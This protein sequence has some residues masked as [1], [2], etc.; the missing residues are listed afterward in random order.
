MTDPTPT[1]PPADP[2]ADL[3][4]PAPEET[5]PAA[6][7]TQTLARLRT[8]GWWGPAS[9]LPVLAWRL[10][11]GGLA[12]Q[13]LAVLTTTGRRTGAP[14]RTVVSHIPSGEQTYVV[15]LYGPGSQWFR[16][17]IADP[18]V[19]VQTTG[20]ARAMLARRLAGD[21]DLRDAYADLRRLLGPGVDAMLGVLGVPGGL[22]GLLARRDR[23]LLVRLEATEG[24]TPPPVRA[25]LAWAPPLLLGSL[26]VVWARSR[27]RRRRRRRR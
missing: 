19:T 6:R 16:N 25:D 8:L 14:R 9:R 5:P 13:A 12:G 21:D 2:Q 17:V 7:L 15:A 10:G 18:R 26:A 11:L 24:P 22:D 1:D 20:A 27:R 23:V 3:P 4:L